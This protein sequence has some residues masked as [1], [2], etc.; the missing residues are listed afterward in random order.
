MFLRRQSI[1]EGVVGPV[2][3]HVGELQVV[4][5]ALWAILVCVPKKRERANRV[6]SAAKPDAVTCRVVI[7]R[8]D[9]RNRREHDGNAGNG[10]FPARGERTVLLDEQTDIFTLP[11]GCQI[12]LMSV[13]DLLTRCCLPHT[14]IVGQRPTTPSHFPRAA[15][16]CLC[17]KVA[18]DRGPAAANRDLPLPLF[19]DVAHRCGSLPNRPGGPRCFRFAKTSR[20]IASNFSQGTTVPIST[21]RWRVGG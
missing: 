19:P 11:R 10:M 15:V 5:R 13:S 3:Q 6:K 8:L 4:K 7:C 12:V 20:K 18:E 16:T 21:V 1:L 9:A 2:L 14:S 17:W